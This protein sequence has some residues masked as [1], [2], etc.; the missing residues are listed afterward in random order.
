MEETRPLLGSK[1]GRIRHLMRSVL[2]KLWNHLFLMAK[3]AASG[4]VATA[5]DYFLY[6]LL[7]YTLFTPV[8]SNVISYSIA[9]FLNFF[10]QKKFVFSLQGSAFKTFVMSVTVSIGGLLLSTAIVYGLT[11][12]PFFLEQQYFTKLIATAIV[13]FYNF[14]LK[15]LV[16]EKRL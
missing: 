12:I 7:V 5:T 1:F 14:Y 2:V 15:R 4:F 6:L 13:F 9:M 3:F 16:F 10:L 11:Q 8:P